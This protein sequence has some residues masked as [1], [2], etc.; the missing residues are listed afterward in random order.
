MLYTWPN[1]NL[2][3]LIHAHWGSIC[4]PEEKVRIAVLKDEI[5][6]LK[7]RIEPRETGHLHTAISVIQHRLKELEVD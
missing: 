5:E 6:L 1:T 2:K 4:A 3:E 7:S